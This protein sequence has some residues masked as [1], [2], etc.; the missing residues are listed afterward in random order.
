MKIFSITG[1]SGSGK[2]LLITRLIKDFKANG[3]RVVAVKSTHAD[4]A[5]QP[6]GKDTARFLQ[7]G[8]EEVY[9]LT[10]KEMLHMTRSAS[11]DM[12]LDS[13]RAR[14]G[15]RDIVLLEGLT[16]PG[17]PVIEVQDPQQQEP[18]KSPPHKLAAV[19]GA[20]TYTHGRPCFHPD[21]IAGIKSFMEAYHEKQDH[22]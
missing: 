8:A 3:R 13:L 20:S 22:P 15:A 7:A 2:T 6:E 9:L 1:W 16:R 18:L 10:E 5:L 12:L 11:P 17:I 14:L 19:I 4:Y 21:D